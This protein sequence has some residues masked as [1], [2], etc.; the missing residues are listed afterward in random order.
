MPS[1]RIDYG[2]DLASPGQ[3]QPTGSVSIDAFGLAQAQLT[4]ALDSDPTNL[5]DAIDT[6]ELGVDYPDDLG[7][8]MKSYKYHIAS[9][10]G[11]VSMLTVDYIGVSR[12]VG[13]TD[14]QITGVSNTM[15]QPIETHPNFTAYDTRFNA[16]PL[17]GTQTSPNNGAIFVPVNT[18]S[19]LA[20][21]FSFGG[22]A[23]SNT[24]TQNK[25]AGVRQYLRP[26]VNIRGQIFFGFGEGDKVNK[27]ASSTGMIV[28]DLSDLRK[29]IA[30]LTG[31][32]N[33]DAYKYAL[34]TSVNIESIG[35][36]ESGKH[37]IKATYDLMIANDTLGWDLD[38]YQ[39]APVSIF[40]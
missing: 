25:K 1:T 26:M 10:K 29:L 34:I 19:G 22:F 7:F 14:A 30:P 31:G 28:H 11:G 23:V 16:G 6:Y 33:P 9:A 4:F 17:A 35:S 36:V 38:I 39:I 3:R 27:L 8:P 20:Q 13:Y 21:Q 37:V 2:A 24:S 5:T 15:A 18:P 12:G 40:A 32:T